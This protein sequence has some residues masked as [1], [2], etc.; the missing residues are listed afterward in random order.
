MIT[1]SI[2]RL[3]VHL[4]RNK[5]DNHNKRHLQIL[6]SRRRRL[7]QY[8]IRNDYQNYRLVIKEFG[9]RPIPIFGSKHALKTRTRTHKQINERNKRLKNRNSRGGKGH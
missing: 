8:M 2:N 9:L 1:D 6:T 3:S 7:L 4:Q 5:K